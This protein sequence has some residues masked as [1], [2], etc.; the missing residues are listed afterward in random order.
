[1]SLSSWHVD[2]SLNKIILELI[3]W[4]NLNHAVAEFQSLYISRQKKRFPRKFL[5]ARPSRSLDTC[6]RALDRAWLLRSFASSC[7]QQYPNIHQYAM[8]QHIPESF[9]TSCFVEIFFNQQGK[10]RLATRIRVV[11][12]M[13]STQRKPHSQPDFAAA[14]LSSCHPVADQRRRPSCRIVGP[15]S[16]ATRY[17]ESH[18]FH[19][20]FTDSETFCRSSALW[21]FCAASRGHFGEKQ[22]LWYHKMSCIPFIL[23]ATPI[24]NWLL[25]P[26]NLNM[27]ILLDCR[28]LPKYSG[29]RSTPAAMPYTWPEATWL[30][31]LKLH[32]LP[33]DQRWRPSVLEGARSAPS[34][35]T[36][37]PWNK[38]TPRIWIRIC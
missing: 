7:P 26:F 15:I 28:P 23:Y 12:T 1:M 3:W 5:S 38:K 10:D 25:W 11:K 9:L 24:Y 31:C 33:G 2:E 22:I 4:G 29:Y 36:A 17:S 8:P 13:F 18:T 27:K 37:S 14:A 6:D 19:S 21:D 20:L 32:F 30:F 34:Y 16:Q 35:V